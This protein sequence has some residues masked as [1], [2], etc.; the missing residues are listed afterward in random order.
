M[1]GRGTLI[2]DSEDRIALKEPWCDTWDCDDCGPNRL[3]RCRGEVA[4][5]RPNKFLTLPVDPSRFA[6][7]WA[8]R[9][10]LGT[11]FP[12]LIRKL[13]RIMGF[14]IPYW[15]GCER[16]PSNGYPHLHVALR[17]KYLPQKLIKKIW[18]E[19]GM[20]YI[21]DIRKVWSVGGI[22]HYFTKYMGKG[23]ARYISHKGG[24]RHVSKRYWKSRNW[25]LPDTKKEKKEYVRRP[26]KY[27]RVDRDELILQAA[28]RGYYY[29]PGAFARKEAR[30][31]YIGRGPPP[32]GGFVDFARSLTPGFRRSTTVASG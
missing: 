1:C 8:A 23:L 18:D 19:L 29:A 21:V 13:E 4:A 20:G 24:V 11:A 27:A 12:R 15:V 17:C 6:D 5:G 22:M 32:P 3:K 30:L 2:D 31:T 14:N 10:A 26:W 7:P 16:T 28:K 25:I 9:L